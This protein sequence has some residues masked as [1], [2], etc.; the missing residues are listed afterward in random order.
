MGWVLRVEVGA[1]WSF[2]GERFLAGGDERWRPNAAE[3]WGTVRELSYAVEHEV[4]AHND[5]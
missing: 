3:I 4:Y 1:V 2:V 5:W